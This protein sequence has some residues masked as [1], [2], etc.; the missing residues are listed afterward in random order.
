MHEILTGTKSSEICCH[1]TVPALLVL[2]WNTSAHN[3]SN[4]KIKIYPISI[5]GGELNNKTTFNEIVPVGI[6]RKRTEGDARKRVEQLNL[7]FFRS[8]PRPPFFS[9]IYFPITGPKDEENAFP[10]P[11]MTLKLFSFS[12]WRPIFFLGV[13]PIPSARLFVHFDSGQRHDMTGRRKTLSTLQ[14][15]E[16]SSISV[17]L[18]FDQPNPT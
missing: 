6:E 9:L 17:R 3:L 12:F 5:C 2:T 14:A 13:L 10:L 1:R 18:H 11:L 7:L 4:C 15:K 8:F 16:I